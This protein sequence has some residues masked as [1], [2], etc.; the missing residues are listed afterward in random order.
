LDGGQARLIVDALG[1]CSPNRCESEQ[2]AS[3]H[4]G[5]NLVAQ[6]LVDATQRPR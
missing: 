1:G 3:P 6:Q 5:A 2:L 4:L